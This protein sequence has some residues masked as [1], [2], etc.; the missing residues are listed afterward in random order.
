MSTYNAL[1]ENGWKMRDIDEMDMLGY[2]QVRAWQAKREQEKKQPVRRYIDEV[3][4]NLQP[5]V[6]V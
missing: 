4:D 1:L 5:N 6:R 2:L 3:W